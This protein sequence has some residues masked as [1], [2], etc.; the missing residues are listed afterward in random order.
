MS[1]HRGRETESNRRVSKR[2][3]LSSGPK[4]FHLR[5]LP[6]PYVNLSV[7]TA[8]VARWSPRGGNERAKVSLADQHF[9]RSPFG[10]ERPSMLVGSSSPVGAS[11]LERE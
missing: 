9:P 8:P 4:D 7:H 6:E 11:S 1:V 5:A 2:R 3:F 10:I